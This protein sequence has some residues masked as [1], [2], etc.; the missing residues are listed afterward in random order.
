VNKTR[1]PTRPISRFK[2]AG[3]SHTPPAS[4][5]A[6]VR[7]NIPAN[8][9]AQDGSGADDLPPL[10][11]S[12]VVRSASFPQANSPRQAVSSQ[13]MV[14]TDTDASDV[15]AL[16]AIRNASL[17][18]DSLTGLHEENALL[19]RIIDGLKR[20]HEV[21]EVLQILTSLIKFVVG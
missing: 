1:T 18:Q 13:A 8:G 3:R 4:S 9:D 15:E 11:G 20:Q 5:T 21:Q 17:D 12:S 7:F 2:P 10:P 14:V 19:G 16:D 6:T